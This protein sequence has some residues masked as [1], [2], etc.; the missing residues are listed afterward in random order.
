MSSNDRRQSVDDLEGY[1]TASEGRGRHSAADRFANLETVPDISDCGIATA[2]EAPLLEQLRAELEPD[3]KA[4]PNA[5]PELVGGIRLLRFLQGHGTVKKAAEAYRR[6]LVWRSEAG[7]DAVREAVVASGMGGEDLTME[8]LRAIEA[9]PFY[10][11]IMAHLPMNLRR[12]SSRSH[13]SSLM[14]ELATCV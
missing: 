11:E 10:S 12:V 5:Y 8:N 13:P 9:W 14:D 6:H 2:E 7:I 1:E 4:V 3:L